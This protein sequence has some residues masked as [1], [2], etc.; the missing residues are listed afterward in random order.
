MGLIGEVKL[1]R[2]SIAWTNPL[3]LRTTI[4]R[5]PAAQPREEAPSASLPAE[6]DEDGRRWVHR[7]T[8]TAPERYAV[9]R[10]RIFDYVK[11]HR[12]PS[13]STRQIRRDLRN[14]VDFFTDVREIQTHSEVVPLADDIGA[15]Q[16]LPELR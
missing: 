7:F 1:V 3:R 13:E 8:R 15:N 5:K 6:F 9:D 2:G 10:E 4:L 16:V 12:L 11:K 14:S